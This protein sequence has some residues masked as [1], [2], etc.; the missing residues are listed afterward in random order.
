MRAGRV[1]SFVPPAQIDP[2]P[3]HRLLPFDRSVC[4]GVNWVRVPLLRLDLNW[5]WKSGTK[6]PGGELGE[7][8][9]NPVELSAVW[10]MSQNN[11]AD[12]WIKS[13][14]SMLFVVSTIVVYT[15]LKVALLLCVLLALIMDLIHF[16]CVS[17]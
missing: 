3:S 17:K 13:L 16:L 5:T 14:S 4:R 7:N 12:L 10:G 2:S 9:V 15:R 8:R 11:I 6:Q 1:K